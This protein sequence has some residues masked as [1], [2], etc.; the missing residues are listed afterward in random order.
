MTK[1]RSPCD[2]ASLIDRDFA[3]TIFAFN[4]QPSPTV[5]HDDEVRLAWRAKCPVRHTAVKCQPSSLLAF[6][7]NLIVQS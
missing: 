7:K 5:E 1:L 6:I 4:G 3:L 2:D